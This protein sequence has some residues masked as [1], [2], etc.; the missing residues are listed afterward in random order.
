MK[1]CPLNAFPVLL[2]SPILLALACES[3]P[4]PGTGSEVEA[5]A[6]ARLRVVHL[7]PDAPAIDAYVGS[8]VAVTDLSFTEESAVGEVPAGRI[9]IAVTAAGAELSTAVATLTDVILEEDRAYTA[10]AFGELAELQ[11]NTIEDSKQGLASDRVRVRV[12]HAAAGVGTVDVYEL[13]G[14]DGSVPLAENLRYGTLADP[15]DLPE[16]AF[17]VGIDVDADG[18]SDLHFEVPALSAGTIVN[19]FALAD[20]ADVFLLAQLDGQVTVR[21]DPSVTQLRV[22]HLSPDSPPVDA[23][24]DGAMPSNFQTISFTESTRYTTLAAGNHSLDVSADGTVAGAVISAPSLPLDSDGKY[25]A[26]AIDSLEDIS[27][28]VFEDD[29]TGLDEG[30]IRVRAIHAAPAVG[31]VDVLNV[32]ADGTATALVSNVDFGEFSNPLD[33]NA[34]AYTLGVDVDDDGAPEVYFELPELPAGTLANVYITQDADG[35]VFAL[36]QL[37]GSTTAVVPLATSEVRVIHM[38]RDAPNVDV[39]ADGGLVVSDLAYTE[40]TG[41][42]IVPSGSYDLDVT[43]AGSSPDEA[44][45]QV[46][47]ATFLPSRAYTVFAY[48]DLSPPSGFSDRGL[49]ANIVEDY[50]EGLDETSDIRLQAIHVATIVTRGDLYSVT[51]SGNTLLVDDFGFGDAAITPDLPSS[52]YTVGFDAEAN[53]VI[54][55]DFDLPVLAPGNFANVFVAVDEADAVYVLVQTAGAGTIRVDPN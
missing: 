30:K 24:V 44:V 15:V 26:I 18:Q 53:G 55:I 45:I 19:V 34:G 47:D 27:A 12:V 5:G 20:G 17:V 9:D 36:A 11:L 46:S 16:E 32:A 37:G 3:K 14:G 52:A 10:F 51:P 38:S 1:E 33:I 50:T 2:F 25:T 8:S 23:F 49:R 21:I 4:A 28:I 35:D 39:Y 6:T 31:Q 41:A 22:L 40:T 7:G 43:V 48:G 13:T 42:L 29:A 54:D